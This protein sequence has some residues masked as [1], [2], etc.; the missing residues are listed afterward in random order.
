[1]N[2]LAMAVTLTLA[3]MVSA[4]DASPYPALRVESNL[5]AAAAKCGSPAS[6]PERI[7]VTWFMGAITEFAT[8]GG[9][10]PT[11]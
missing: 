2:R 3:G 7:C 1:M 11:S 8:R 10:S 4:D 5:R 9:T 6:M